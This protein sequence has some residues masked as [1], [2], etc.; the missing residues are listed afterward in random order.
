VSRYATIVADPP[1]KV[2]AGRRLGVEGFGDTESQSAKPTDYQSMT[3]DK[4]SA[5]RVSDVAQDDA[6]LYLWTTNGYLPAAF[7]VAHAWGFRYST[8]LVWAKN[9]MGGGLGGA[10]GISTEFCLFCRRGNLATLRDVGGTWFNWKRP[11]DAR[12]KPRHSAKPPEFFAMV[13]Q[14]SPGPYLELFAREQRLGWDSWGN[15]V[16]GIE[17]P[18]LVCEQREP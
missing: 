3:V 10:Y 4:I 17:L 18:S 5:M 16:N 7:E 6:H 13:D 14:V 12:G 2:M 15:E 11:Y 8:T 9:L 1:W